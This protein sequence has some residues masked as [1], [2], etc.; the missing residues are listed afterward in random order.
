M[1][2]VLQFMRRRAS[3]PTSADTSDVERLQKHRDN[4]DEEVGDKEETEVDSE[5]EEMRR[6]VSQQVPLPPFRPRLPQRPNPLPEWGIELLNRLAGKPIQ[7]Q[8]R[9][10]SRRRLRNRPRPPTSEEEE[11]DTEHEPREEEGHEERVFDWNPDVGPHVT[12]RMNQLARLLRTKRTGRPTI[13]GPDIES[14]L[15]EG[16][17]EEAHK[18]QEELETLLKEFEENEDGVNEQAEFI[19]LE[20][21]ILQLLA[22]SRSFR[23]CRREVF[24]PDERCVQNKKFKSLGQLSNHMQAKHG[25]TKEETA[26]MFRYFIQRMLPMEIEM[27]VTTSSEQEVKRDW[28]FSQCHHPGCT[29][30]NTRLTWS[31]VT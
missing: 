17:E 21:P 2:D 31:T 28:K 27:K 7:V 8:P 25:A 1:E 23:I 10:R 9:A 19:F 12:R 14:D 5:V 3:A 29:Y 18:F 15:E 11:P 26:D 24:C 6:Q 16:E 20:R 4:S 13:E 22:Q 30:I